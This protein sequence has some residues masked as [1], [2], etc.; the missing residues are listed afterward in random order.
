MIEQPW[1]GFASD[2][3]AG[4]H[5]VV[6]EAIS[7]ANVDHQSA[8]GDDVVTERAASMVK[9]LFG[10]HADFYPV[11]NGTGANVVRLVISHRAV[12]VSRSALLRRT[13]TPTRAGLP[14]SG[15]ERSV[16]G[17]YTGL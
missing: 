12:A 6:L 5:G 1:R 10:T 16:D 4:V 17:T 11:F 8:Y 7:R 15:R 3:Y 2:N 13:S 9:E 14:S